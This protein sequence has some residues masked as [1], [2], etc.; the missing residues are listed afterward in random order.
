MIVAPVSRLSRGER[1]RCEDCRHEGH[2]LTVFRTTATDGT[3]FAIYEDPSQKQFDNFEPC[4]LRGIT[5][6]TTLWLWNSY[7]GGHA[8]IAEKLGISVRETSPYRLFLLDLLSERLED[9]RTYDYRHDR[10][11][12]VYRRLEPLL[13]GGRSK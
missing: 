12:S 7:F 2:A 3:M 9:T 1:Y 11:P 6:G 10:L 8:E 4:V 13:R 5:D